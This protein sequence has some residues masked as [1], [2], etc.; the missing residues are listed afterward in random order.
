MRRGLRLLGPPLRA[1][2]SGLVRLGAWSVVET[3][4][5]LLS[6]YLVSR[7]VDA[8]FLAGK[9]EVGAAWLAGFALAHAVGAY[10]SRRT[11]PA[12]GAVVE[13]VR[14]SIVRR[15][16]GATLRAAVHSDTGAGAHESAVSRLNRQVETVRDVLAGLLLSSRRFVLSAG[17]ALIGLLAL[18]PALLLFVLPPL[19]VALLLFGWLALVLIPRHRN[20]LIA[21]E[22]LAHRGAQAVRGRRDTVACGAEGQVAAEVGTAITAHRRAVTAVARTGAL[23][24]F[25]VATGGAA[26]LVLLLAAAPWLTDRGVSTG[27]IL[28]ALTYLSTSLEPA[29]RAFVSSVGSSGLLLAVLLDRLRRVTDLPDTEPVPRGTATPDRYDLILRDVS[30]RYGERSDP[31]VAELRLALPHGTHLAVIGP[32]GIG[33]S[34]LGGLLAGVL[35]PTAG[36]VQLGGTD[37][38][39]VDPDWLRG[40]VT[41]VPQEAYVFT[42]TLRENL[43]YLSPAATDEDLDRVRDLFELDP[44]VRRIGGYD[45]EFTP[46]TLPAGQRQLIVLA[47]AFLGAAK[48][49]ILDEAT[50]H[51]D[52]PAEARVE[53]VFAARAGTL[54]VIAHR[55]SSARRADRILLLDGIRASQ[56]THEQLLAGSPLYAELV[57]HWTD[58]GPPPNGQPNSVS[59]RS[60]SSRASVS[61]ASDTR[62]HP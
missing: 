14:D 54:V 37:L 41:L 47:R 9:P 49:V 50:C 28:G 27:E 53:S 13:G 4:P 25:V 5:I 44:L 39:A 57:S 2:R 11:F 36:Q 52:P 58:A 21:E 35:R 23:R 30:F 59:R 60:P 33:K 15:V 19:A 3:V 40:A 12:L 43:T 26:P 6:G 56:G 34:T 1:Q 10:G 17:A 31:V 16:V 24:A 42:G 46:A 61:V 20:Q 51:L 32:S 18:D 62:T 45:T 8:G 29:L 55:I 38:A 7:A 48:I 22:R